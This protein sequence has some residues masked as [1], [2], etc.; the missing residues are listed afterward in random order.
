ME[1]QPKIDAL[2]PIDIN[3][4]IKRYDLKSGWNGLKL[5][6]RVLENSAD[7][8]GPLKSTVGGVVALIDIYDVCAAFIIW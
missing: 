3:A 2:S 4:A 6:L 1:S 7:A 8:F 5:L